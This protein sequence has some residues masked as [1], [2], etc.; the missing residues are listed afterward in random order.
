M[1]RFGHVYTLADAEV[2]V[3]WYVPIPFLLGQLA[4][5][6]AIALVMFVAG[7]LPVLALCFEPMVE[8]LS[9]AELH[10]QSVALLIFVFGLVTWGLLGLAAIRNRNAIFF[11]AVQLVLFGRGRPGGR[12]EACG[13]GSGSGRRAADG[14]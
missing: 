9:L 3:R 1:A 12:V 5:L 7:C 10:G 13:R 14:C 2:R 6:S 8:R 4:P 11:G